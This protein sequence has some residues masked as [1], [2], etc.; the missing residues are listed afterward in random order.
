MSAI[1]NGIDFICGILDGK[2]T[3]SM[4]AGDGTAIGLTYALLAFGWLVVLGHFSDRD[5]S[6]IVTASSYSMFMGYVIL[7]I[8]V[9]ATKSVAGLS[10][11]TLTLSVVYYIT[12]LLATS[13]KSG[14]NPV[15]ATGD[16]MYQLIDFSCLLL[17]MH[18]LYCVHKTHV[19]SYQEELDTLPIRPIVMTSA[20]L[21]FFVRANFN[22]HFFFDF[23]FAMSVN[24]ETLTMVPQ[25]WMLAKMGGKIDMSTCHFVCASV[26]SNVLTFVWWWFC[27]SELEKRGP[28]LLAKVIIGS[29]GVKLLLAADFM[30][31]YFLAWFNGKSVH[32]PVQGDADAM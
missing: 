4:G 27:A 8:K 3:R 13:L 11:K 14:Y 2:T 24:I 18:L 12:R 28:C 29:Q 23:C 10:S 19:H 6:C 17:I 25:L 16:F 5:F 7:C 31:Y 30:Y 26:V 22:R 1:A 32:L 20:F 15:D 21:G 9:H